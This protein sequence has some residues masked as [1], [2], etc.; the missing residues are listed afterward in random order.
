MTDRLREAEKVCGVSAGTFRDLRSVP[1]DPASKLHVFAGCPP[2]PAYTCLWEF[3]TNEG[4]S[5]RELRISLVGCPG[6]GV[7]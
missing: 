6:D 4:L 5:D 3:K 2:S 1:D 7:E